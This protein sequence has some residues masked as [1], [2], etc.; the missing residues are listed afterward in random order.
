M[1]SG[2]RSAILS[3]RAA[4]ALPLPPLNWPLTQFHLKSLGC[5][6]AETGA[7]LIEIAQGAT[8]LREDEGMSRRL[9]REFRHPVI[10]NA[11]G[12]LEAGRLDRREFVRIAALLGA[13][14][15]SAYALVGLPAPALAEGSLP[16]PPDD[17]K[18]KM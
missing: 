16:F 3:Q 4:N 17:P 7:E 11:F 2:A 8:N 1:R 6:A 5:A 18:A 14:A 13:S 9:P 15:A 12:H 10:Q